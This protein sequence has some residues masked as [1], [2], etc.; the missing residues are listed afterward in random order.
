MGTISLIIKGDRRQATK[1]AADRGV[2]FD[3]RNEIGRAGCNP[4]TVGLTSDDYSEEVLAWY[5]EP[6]AQAPY[7]VGTLLVWSEE[8]RVR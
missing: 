1:A 8:T 6:P 7:P 3:F 5:Q 4:E 2:P